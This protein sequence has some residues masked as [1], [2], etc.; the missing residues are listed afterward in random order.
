MRLKERTDRNRKQTVRNIYI[1]YRHR[2]L[3]YKA[4]KSLVFSALRLRSEERRDW[5]ATESGE[6]LRDER[7]VILAILV[8]SPQH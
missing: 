3:G 6:I 2:R 8:T 1:P 7:T 4:M 5:Q